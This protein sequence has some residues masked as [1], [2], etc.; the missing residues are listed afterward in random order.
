M[1]LPRLTRCALTSSNRS[2]FRRRSYDPFSNRWWPVEDG[3]DARPVRLVVQAAASGEL[4]PRRMAGRSV[5]ERYAALHPD[6][7]DERAEGRRLRRK[8]E[9]RGDVPGPRVQEL[10]DLLQ[11]PDS[12]GCCEHRV[13]DGK[14]V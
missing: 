14:R 5:R 1:G 13:V 7:R 12:I 2:C 4:Q 6:A 10:Q 3:P 8:L 11:H 9:R